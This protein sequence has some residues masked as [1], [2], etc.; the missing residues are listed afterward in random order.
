MTVIY[1]QHKIIKLGNYINF[2]TAIH[3]DLNF[4]VCICDKQEIVIK[5]THLGTDK[6]C[7]G[8]FNNL[9]KGRTPTMH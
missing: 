7:K 3:I 5:S 2:F 9:R 8:T 1:S 6:L 4:K